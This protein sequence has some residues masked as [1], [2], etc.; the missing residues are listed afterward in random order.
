MRCATSSLHVLQLY[1]ELLGKTVNELQVGVCNVQGYV[2]DGYP[3]NVRQ[4]ELLEGALTGLDLTAERAFIASASR[5]APPRPATLPDLNRSLTSGLVNCRHV[6]WQM[7]FSTLVASNPDSNCIT[8]PYVPVCIAVA[9]LATSA[10]CLLACAGLDAVVVLELDDEALAVKRALGR[11][12]DPLTG[13]VYHLEFDVPPP[14]EPGLA[15]RLKVGMHTFFRL[16]P[17]MGGLAA[18]L[19]C[20]F[21]QSQLLSLTSLNYCLQQ[22]ISLIPACCVASDCFANLRHFSPSAPILA[23]GWKHHVSCTCLKMFAVQL[24]PGLCCHTR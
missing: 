24:H 15:A 1:L 4:A 17:F 14:K 20:S 2:M 3:S 6:V 12:V 10:S 16:L 18:C 23:L 11:R 19:S 13:R 5:L 22:L 21:G 7:V 9:L 8:L